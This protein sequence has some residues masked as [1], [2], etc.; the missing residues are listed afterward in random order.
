MFAKDWQHYARPGA[1]S[2]GSKKQ[3]RKIRIR[4]CWSP[5]QSNCSRCARTFACQK[6]VKYLLFRSVIL[7]RI[8]F[9]ISASIAFLFHSI[10]LFQG[11]RRGEPAAPHPAA[12]GA[13]PRE[14]PLQPG[15]VYSDQMQLPE[16]R[17][18]LS[19][20][21]PQGPSVPCEVC[22]GRCWRASLRRSA[23]GDRCRRWPLPSRIGFCRSAITTVSNPFWWSTN[24]SSSERDWGLFNWELSAS[25]CLVE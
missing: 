22:P 10:C 17:E 5:L 13:R 20:P 8:V 15:M 11:L 6:D 18:L 7:V 4:N 14:E 1:A 3:A 12:A 16:A 9:H 2:P 25:F 21:I 19:W 24:T 23:S